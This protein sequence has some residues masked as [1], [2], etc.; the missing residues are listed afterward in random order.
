MQ[1]A[2]APLSSST[3][4]AVEAGSGLSKPP[5]TAMPDVPHDT[6]PMHVSSSTYYE[7][8]TAAP[9]SGPS[10]PHLPSMPEASSYVASSPAPYPGSPPVPSPGPAPSSP[11]AQS[12]SMPAPLP[13]PDVPGSPVPSQMLPPAAAGSPLVM[14]MPEPGLNEQP[15]MPVPMPTGPASP[16]GLPTDVPP[17]FPEPMPVGPAP[18]P[19]TSQ[20]PPLGH[21][22]GASSSSL[23]LPQPQHFRSS[24]MSAGANGTQIGGQACS[25][26]P[27]YMS[28][29]NPSAYTAPTIHTAYT[30]TIT[31]TTTVHDDQ[32]LYPASTDALY[33]GS[34][35]ATDSIL[36]REALSVHSIRTMD[37]NASAYDASIDAVYQGSSRVPSIGSDSK[38]S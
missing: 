31:P 9:A 26:S 33:N 24:D 27:S 17:A 16:P 5:T 25:R 8:N 7:S 3:P 22:R 21:H 4:A 12:P 35:R 18:Y 6:H 36:S 10:S 20:Q 32:S 28:T 38:E 29:Y 34:S 2:A 37:E 30:R 23:S 13:R 11:L 14:P 1:Q 15:T 19:L